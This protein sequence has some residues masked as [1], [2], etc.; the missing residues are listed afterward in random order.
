MTGLSFQ[1]VVEMDTTTFGGEK[2]RS[3]L[4]MAFYE[5]VFSSLQA[6]RGIS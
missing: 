4:T 6:G 5:S 1:A 3:I 2:N